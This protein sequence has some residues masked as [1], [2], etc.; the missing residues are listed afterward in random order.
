MQ[1]KFNE[2]E[3]G[4]RMALGTPYYQG[5]TGVSNLDTY[6]SPNFATG[7]KEKDPQAGSDK[8][9]TLLPTEDEPSGTEM[10]PEDFESGIEAIKTVVTPDEIIAGMQYILK[11]MVFK[12]RDDAKKMVVACLKKDPK[13]F[14]KLKMFDDELQNE[15]MQKLFREFY[16]TSTER[17]ISTIME[18]LR[19]KRYSKK[20][21]SEQLVNHQTL[22]S[23]NKISGGVSDSTSP[24]HINPVELAMGVAVEMEHTTDEKVAAEIALDHLSKEPNYY[25]K[26]KNAGLADELSDLNSGSG[27]G[28]NNHIINN[29]PRLGIQNHGSGNISGTIGNTPDGQIDGHPESDSFVNQNDDNYQMDIEIDEDRC[30]DIAKRKYKKWPSAYASGAVVRCRNGEIWKKNEESELEERFDKEKKQG[31]HGWFSRRGGEGGKGW[32]DCNT[33]RKDPKTG[34]KKCKS[35]GR[36]AGEKRS[37]YPACRPTPS[38]CNTTGTG[39]K[40]GPKQV[41][42]KKNE[43]SNDI[44]LKNIIEDI[45]KDE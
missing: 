41:S 37:K 18:E 7:Q 9:T 24:H 39:N 32:V 30:T 26:L 42:W 23:N 12:S 3:L 29:M 25:S 44:K 6:N 35:C 10:S 17:E 34:N 1:H 43:S 28:D 33:C 45:L 5:G 8:I 15:S 38:Q 40:K 22:K 11:K 31:L 13:Y 4:D 19:R 36:Q 27:L 14:S 20:T 2:N 16:Q 21:F